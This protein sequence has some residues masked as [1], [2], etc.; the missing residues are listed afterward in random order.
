[1]FVTFALKDYKQSK[2]IMEKDENSI[3]AE[4]N[5]GEAKCG[6]SDGGD[7]SASGNLFK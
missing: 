1:M 5:T 6:F 2:H 3:L 4:V 7:G